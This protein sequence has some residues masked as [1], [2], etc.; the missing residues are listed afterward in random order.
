LQNLFTTRMQRL[1]FR[2]PVRPIESGRLVRI[3]N[4][5]RVLE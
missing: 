4:L 3:Q 2:S 1:V 5:L